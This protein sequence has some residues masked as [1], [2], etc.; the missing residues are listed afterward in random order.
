M[1]ATRTYNIEAD[2]PV[3]DEARR[4][5]IAEIKRAK[6]EGVRVLK[7]IHG[8]GSSGK[9]GALCVGLRK[10]FGLRKKEGV[11]REFIAGEDFSIFN[12]I[13]LALL[14]LVPEMRGDPDLNAANEGITLL[15]LR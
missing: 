3:L 5:V 6:R 14:E 13:V 15:W 7:V 2:M 1:S 8:Y 9:G 11:I 10:S 12:E 4:S